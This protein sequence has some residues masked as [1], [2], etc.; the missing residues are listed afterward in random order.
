MLRVA[1]RENSAAAAHAAG[2]PLGELHKLLLVGGASHTP[3]LHTALE[4]LLSTARPQPP[5]F[6]PAAHAALQLAP[7]PTAAPLTRTKPRCRSHRHPPRGVLSRCAAPPQAA[8]APT[9]EPY[10]LNADECVAHG[11][12]L[13]ARPVASKTR[14][15]TR[16]LGLSHA[17]RG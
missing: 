7:T 9:L 1:A 14:A 12:A 2:L 8:P 15:S 6:G 16:I 13:H 3:A 5:V 4:Q 11:A 10:I 17:R